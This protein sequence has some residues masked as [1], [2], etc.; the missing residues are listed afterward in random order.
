MS[1]PGLCGEELLDWLERTTE[2]WRRLIAAHPEA[3][4]LPC[5]IRETRT[6]S[7]LLQHIVAAELRYAERLHGLAETP[8]S[9]I[10]SDGGEGIFAVHERAV[11]LLRELS[12][13]EDGFW[14]EWIEFGTRSAGTL[15][16]PRGA[17]FAHLALHSI[18]HYAQLATLVR[19]AGI[20]PG[21]SMDYLAMKAR[22][23]AAE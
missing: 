21:W 2:G 6:V 7:E 20:A 5:D 11:G 18:R 14:D 3:L 16:A 23:G 12:G 9:A 4:E 15:R 10:P 8:Y 1:L 13:R 19:K 22:S 17:V